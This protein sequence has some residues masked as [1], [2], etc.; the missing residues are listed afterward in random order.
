[1]HKLFAI[2]GSV[3]SQDQNPKSQ[4]PHRE[5]PLDSNLECACDRGAL[6]KFC[7]LLWEALRIQ[8]WGRRPSGEPNGRDYF[9]EKIGMILQSI[10]SLFLSEC[11]SS[12]WDQFVLVGKLSMSS[13]ISFVP[14]NWWALSSW[15]RDKFQL[16][17][18]QPMTHAK[19]V[20]S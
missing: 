9:N 16:R 12:S 17:Q 7:L 4:I 5:D 6:A 11:F 19:L 2:F 10:L 20:S 13:K 15:C 18:G 3:V 14:L 8:C 1:M